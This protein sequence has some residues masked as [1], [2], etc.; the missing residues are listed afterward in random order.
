MLDLSPT[1]QNQAPEVARMDNVLSGDRAK[2]IQ[3]PLS[4][5]ALVVAVLFAIAHLA[6]ALAFV[7]PAH[8]GTDANCYLLGGRL[9]ATHG[10]MPFIPPSPYAYVASA[11]MQTS[12]QRC[13][14]KVPIGLPAINAVVWL[15]AGREATYLVS[16]LAASASVFAMFLLARSIGGTFCG[17]LGM[18]LL[19]A[20]PVLLELM[21]VPM[22][23]AVD[24]CLV[25]FGMW[26]LIRWLSTGNSWRAAAAGLMLGVAVTIRY[27]EGLLVLPLL[28][29][30]MFRARLVPR[31]QWWTTLALPVGAWLIPVIA[32][33]GFNLI[34]IHTLTGYDATNES[35]GFAWSYFRAKWLLTLQVLWSDGAFFV[36][37]L[38]MI[39]A[40]LMGV[41]HKRP[42]IVLL[43]WFFPGTLLYTA[44]WCGAEDGGVRYL[45]F[46][47][48]LIPPILIIAA[49]LMSHFWRLIETPATTARAAGAIA[50]GLVVS[51]AALHGVQKSLP[52]LERD[53]VIALNL[54]VV[55]D[56]VRRH[57]PDGSVLFAE[58]TLLNHL[59]YV[60]DFQLY[61]KDAFAKR[62]VGESPQPDESQP[63]IVQRE[64]K[65]L[66]DRLYSGKTQSDLITEQDGVITRALAQGG[67]VFAIVSA[68]RAAGLV[69]RVRRSRKYI[70]RTVERWSDSAPMPARARSVLPELGQGHAYFFGFRIPTE[71]HLLEV[72][73]KASAGDGASPSSP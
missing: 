62:D 31:K 42:L 13:L 7:A 33:L 71:W 17:L 58:N 54:S 11:W 6:F 1:H 9:L 12:D 59:Q 70:V 35:T 26:A 20:N 63:A 10:T 40:V 68:D 16:A 2:A 48:T 25:L 44:Y 55:G 73:P 47:L 72:I 50:A 24:L 18:I 49:W 15:T 65:Q 3:P 60:G 51:V 53:H 64:R 69:A 23:H 67:H 29:A 39:G 36:L 4:A 66:L 38:A 52:A 56:T 43:L 28:G 30:V 46:L 21:A 57:A 61:N 27:T 32:L 8:P 34:T 5:I 22:S 45:R 41:L 19:A 37:P 14:P